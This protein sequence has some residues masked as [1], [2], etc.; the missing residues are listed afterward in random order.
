MGLARVVGEDSRN[1][2]MEKQRNQKAQLLLVL[3]KAL[4]GSFSKQ[5]QRA[6]EGKAGQLHIGRNAGRREIYVNPRWCEAGTTLLL[7]SVVQL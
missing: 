5:D 4:H 2:A 3:G 1:V 6:V 7:S